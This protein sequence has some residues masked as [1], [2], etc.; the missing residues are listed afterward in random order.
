MVMSAM[1][2]VVFVRCEKCKQ[3]KP[4]VMIIIDA[5]MSV[6]L[7]TSGL[8]STHLTND[9]FCQQYCMSLVVVP[10]EPG[11]NNMALCSYHA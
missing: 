3:D 6:M 2:A 11:T 10:G 7:Q 4:S 5:L 1:L 8:H 9:V